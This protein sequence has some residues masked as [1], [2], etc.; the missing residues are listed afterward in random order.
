MLQYVSEGQTFAAAATGFGIDDDANVVLKALS[1]RIAA[2]H[3][4][5]FGRKGLQQLHAMQHQ[6]KSPSKRQPPASPSLACQ[7][8]V[9]SVSR[10]RFGLRR[11]VIWRNNVSILRQM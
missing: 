6:D 3:R 11:A 5:R 7:S 4:L 8:S 10:M 9:P 2:D 1:S